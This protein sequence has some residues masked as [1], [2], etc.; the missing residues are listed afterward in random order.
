[1]R[2]LVTPK[3][4]V[5]TDY[6]SHTLRIVLIKWNTGNQQSSEDPKEKIINEQPSGKMTNS[7]TA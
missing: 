6:D 1:M 2:R 3:I 5:D 4:L 7:D